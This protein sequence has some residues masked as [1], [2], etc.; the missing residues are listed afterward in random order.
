MPVSMNTP[1]HPHTFDVHA[2]C[3][4]P[5][6]KTVAA[7]RL[8]E[9][10]WTHWPTRWAIELLGVATNLQGWTVKPYL[11]IFSLNV[12]LLWREPRNGVLAPL[13]AC[14]CI[15]GDTSK[16]VMSLRSLRPAKN[17]PWRASIWKDELAEIVSKEISFPSAMR[18]KMQDT[19]P[20][21][22]HQAAGGIHHQCSEAA[23]LEHRL[24][25]WGFF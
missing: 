7:K 22:S 23:S 10:L 8:R 3:H 25:F 16:S 4:P 9:F 15:F 21:R 19:Q 5:K 1:L 18:S 11:T 6:A 13:N 17:T 14:P 12:L 24:F 2:E 20:A